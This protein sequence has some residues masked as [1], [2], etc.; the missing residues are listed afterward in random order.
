[1]PYFLSLLA[2]LCAR[3]QEAEM[4]LATVDEALAL[5][6]A[7]NEHWWDAELQRLRGMLLWAQGTELDQVEAAF[8]QALAIARRQQARALELRAANSLAQLWRQNRPDQ[9]FQLLSTVYRQFDRDQDTLDLQE[10]K[11]LLADL[12]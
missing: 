4:G 2:E 11:A 12:A 6:E 8:Q 7:R 1:M 3:A 10:A 9:A 5:A